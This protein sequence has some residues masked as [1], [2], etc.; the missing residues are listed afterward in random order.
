MYD[1]PH[2]KE[3]DKQKVLQFMQ[4]H[5]FAMLI[6]CADNMPVATQVPLLVEEKESKIFLKGHIMRNTGHHKAF[7]KNNNVLCVFSGAQA[8][9]SASWYTN[10]QVASTWNYMSVHARGT[11]TFLSNEHLLQILQL[12][13]AHFENNPYSPA[14]FENLPHD[15]VQRLAKAIIGFEIEVT[16]MD[17]V[18]KLSQNREKESYNDIINNL[19]HGDADAQAIATEMQQRRPQLFHTE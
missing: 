5:P 15:Y 10:P 16:G 19:Q 13:T 14:L 9:V 8:Y 4:D 2:F 18:F 7:E 3:H 11:L 17:T 1:I 6:G 12:T